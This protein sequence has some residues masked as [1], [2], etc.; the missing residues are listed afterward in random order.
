MD[1]RLV[2]IGWLIDLAVDSSA[3]RENMKKT[4]VQLDEF[5]AQHSEGLEGALEKRKSYLKKLETERVLG[6]RRDF[7]EKKSIARKAESAYENGKHKFILNMD[8]Y[9]ETLE[10]D[11]KGLV[12]RSFRTRLPSGWSDEGYAES[13][14][15]G[16]YK[17]VYYDGSVEMMTEFMLRTR[18]LPRADEV[19][20]RFGDSEFFR[21]YIKTPVK[22]NCSLEAESTNTSRRSSLRKRKSV[23]MFSPSFVETSDVVTFPYLFLTIPVSG[24]VLSP[25]NIVDTRFGFGIVKEVREDSDESDNGYV[26]DLVWG[27]VCVSPNEIIEQVATLNEI[28]EINEVL[29]QKSKAKDLEDYLLKHSK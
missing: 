26:I 24:W 23:A 1:E 29:L 16:E 11:L 27:Q 20:S 25:G 28:E 21:D 18:L 7:E 13:I 6:A 22:K 10:N 12:G 2:I 8:G 14:V 17:C 9:D 3:F 19:A 4:V 5:E 15:D